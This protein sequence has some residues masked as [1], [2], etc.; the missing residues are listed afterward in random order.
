MTAPK[1]ENTR[2]STRS[3]K[4]IRNIRNTK[5]TSNIRSINIAKI[6]KSHARMTNVGTGIVLKERKGIGAIGIKTEVIV[7]VGIEAKG[8]EGIVAIGIEI[9]NDVIEKEAVGKMTTAEE[10]TA[11]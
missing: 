7:I 10:T 6:G 3:T 5:S 11:P 8:T 1:N 9:M 2:R 4:N